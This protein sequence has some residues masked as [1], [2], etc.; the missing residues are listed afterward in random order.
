MLYQLSYAPTAP[1]V[2]TGGIHSYRNESSAM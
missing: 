1:A 2:E